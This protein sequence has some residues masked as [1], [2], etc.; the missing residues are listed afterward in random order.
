[1]TKE[2]VR[3]YADYMHDEYGDLDSDYVFVNLWGGVIASPM[4]YQ[5]VRDL[6]EWTSG[7]VGFRFT[8][9][10]FRHTFTTLA[11]REGVPLDVVSRLVT[12]TSTSTMSDV[13]HEVLLNRVG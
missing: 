12:H 6:V 3:L 8:A 10:M 1:M 11:L 2:S 13:R 5:T 4:T 9:H 7:R